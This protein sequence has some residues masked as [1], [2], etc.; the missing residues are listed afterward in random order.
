M[1]DELRSLL[2]QYQ[3]VNNVQE[4]LHWDQETYMPKSALPIHSKGLG[5]LSKIQ[6]DLIGSDTFE[7][8]LTTY[9]ANAEDREDHVMARELRRMQHEIKAVPTDLLK[10]KSELKSESLAAWKQAKETDD[11]DVFKPYLKEMFDIAKETAKHLDPTSGPYE[12][13]FALYEPCLKIETVDDILSELKQEIPGRLDEL[14]NQEAPEN[15]IEGEFNKGRQLGFSRE[16]AQSLGLKPTEHRLD[17]STHPFTVGSPFAT[18]ITT[19]F[20]EK[21]LINT[22]TSTAHET[23][24]GLYMVGLPEEHWNTPRGWH[25]GLSIHESQSRFMENHVAR[26]K[27]FWEH[28]LPTIKETFPDQLKGV[29]TEAAFRA[30]NTV[31]FENKIRV[32]ADELTYHLH[33]AIR[34][35]I[36]KRVLNGD[37]SVDDIPRE[38]NKQMKSLLGTTPE[39]LG[40]GC[41]QDIHWA[42]GSIGYFPT[43]TLGSIIAAQLDEALRNDLD[44]NELIRNG[45]FTPLVEWH[46]E[47]IHRHGQRY[48]TQTLVEKAT[49]NPI[50]VEPF[51][52]YIDDKLSDVYR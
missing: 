5:A 17:V 40:E 21:N 8:A 45:D 11:F 20:N 22:I 52:N 13:L 23:G 26:T 27:A 28:I 2:S 3:A 15:V 51:L 42:Q 32:D 6:S 41:L 30:A 14:R 35:D 43:Y 49:G 9:E 18:R 1:N 10:R 7:E 16:L 36:E 12:P 50:S 24:H 47:H 4:T 38:W 37:L 39:T 19:R 34:Y 25:R 29:S 46:R 44:K 48:A 31:N 33:I